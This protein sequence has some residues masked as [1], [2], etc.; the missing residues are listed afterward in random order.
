MLPLRLFHC[1]EA[2]SQS[3]AGASTRCSRSQDHLLRFLE[4]VLEKIKVWT[5]ETLLYTPQ[6]MRDFYAGLD[7]MVFKMVKQDKHRIIT[8]KFILKTILWCSYISPLLRM[9]GN[10]HTE[11]DVTMFYEELNRG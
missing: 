9:K 7:I 5:S 11:M 2:A 1:Q 4:G 3:K 6:T 10:L 8:K